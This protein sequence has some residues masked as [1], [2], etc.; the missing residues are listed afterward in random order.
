MADPSFPD[1]PPLPA[2]GSHPMAGPTRVSR[3]AVASLV[4]GLLACPFSILS[5]IPGLVCGIMGLNRI[6]RSERPH[7]SP[8]L[9]GQG[10]AIAGVVLSGLS[11]LIL[12][13]MVGLMLPAVQAARE[14]ARR[15]MCANNLVQMG[16]GML[17]HESA[18]RLVPAAI[19]DAQ[20]T[21]LLSWRV[22]ILPYLDEQALY[23]EF[24]LDEPWD[25]EHNRALIPRMPA[26][27]ACPSAPTAEG[28]TLYLLL[29]GPGAGC[30]KTRQRLDGRI[31]G[32]RLDDLARDGS[33]GTIMIVE[34]PSSAALEWTRPADLTVSPGEAARLGDGPGGSG[35]AGGI[36]HAVYAD[37]HVEHL[38]PQ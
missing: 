6:A 18:A 7:A 32:V 17:R 24:H 9:S 28:T 20:G 1:L 13:V 30:E 37:G 11:M 38:F 16:L 8:R 27:Y 2:A 26:V 15:T 23:E 29:D 22:A 31:R 35:H 25:S 33:A 3:L 12:P 5:G 4:F 10:M 14:A 21:P 36:R 19:T 34:V